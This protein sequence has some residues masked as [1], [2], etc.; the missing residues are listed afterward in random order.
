MFAK[1]ASQAGRQ[2]GETADKSTPGDLFSI[3]KAVEWVGETPAA[4]SVAL[5]AI[6]G[7]YQ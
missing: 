2:A 5:G 6:R 7:F 4:V 3:F 1:A